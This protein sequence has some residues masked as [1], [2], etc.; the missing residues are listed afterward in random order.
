[1]KKYTI[2]RTHTAV[3]EKVITEEELNG[4]TIEQ[5]ID[6]QGNDGWYSFID[7]AF[8]DTDDEINWFYV[9]E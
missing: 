6:E 9:E 2:S 5:Y 8:L 7:T 4:K 3:W 1:M